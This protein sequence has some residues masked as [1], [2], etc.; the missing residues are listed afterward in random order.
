[1]NSGINDNLNNNDK[2]NNNNNKT[3]NNISNTTKKTG[4]GGIN[5]DEIDKPE[6]NYAYD[7]VSKTAD[8]TR[9]KSEV[10][11]NE[12][13]EDDEDEEDDENDEKEGKSKDKSEVHCPIFKTIDTNNFI[14]TLLS[15]RKKTAAAT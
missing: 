5:P 2:N 11:K 4:N 1:M 7:D 12:D 6:S 3:G 13:D 10:D 8:V 15:Q 9:V 14:P